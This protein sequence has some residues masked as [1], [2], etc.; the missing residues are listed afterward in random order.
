MEIMLISVILILAL[1]F[2]FTEK[3]TVDMVGIGIIV[4]LMLTRILSPIEAVRGF[5]NPAVITVGSMFIISRGMIRTGVVAFLARITIGL[6]RGNRNLMMLVV[7]LVVAGASAFINNTPVVVLFIPI[8]LSLSCEYDFS[9]SKLLIPMSY[10]SI[11]GGTCTLIGTSTNIIVSDLS[12]LYGFGKISM[13]ELSYL[14]VPLA[15]LGIAVIYLFA[16]YAMPEHAVPV[17]ELR[18]SEHRRYLAE[19]KVPRGSRMIGKNPAGFLAQKY[20]GIDVF[21]L[22]RYSHVFYPKEEDEVIAAADDLLLVKGELNDL[23]G[24][25]HDKIVELSQTAEAFNFAA[26]ADKSLI[27]ELIVPPQSSLVGERVSSTELHGDPDYHVIA[28]K[29]TYLRYYEKQIRNVELR[30]GDILLVR[31]PENRLDD[32]RRTGDFIIVEDVHHEIILKSKAR[33]AFLIFLGIVAAASSGLADIMEC[34]VTGVFLMILTGCIKLR[35][36][37]RAVQG[38]VL[39]LIVGAIALGA[40]MEKTGASEFYA[41][42]FLRAFR[43]AEPVIVLGG[44]LLLTSLST[45]LLSNNAAAALLLPIAISTAQALGVNPK[46]FIIA[47]CFGASACYSTPIGY[48]TN[49]LVFGPGNYRFRDYLKLGIPLNILVICMGILFIP[50][51]WPF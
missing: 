51:I 10:V 48:Q 27:V 28:I 13:F 29:R 46:P 24:I 35:D 38:D 30:V 37:Y 40:A 41:N 32:L 36:A 15:L 8:I 11:L 25:L 20:P 44:F 5:A 18:D 34:A 39:I 6:S 7:L 22:I 12:D 26:M 16:R 19:L 21:E 23:V 49:L 47:V 9:P 3:M 2:L 45:Q 33:W 50:M 42:G 4:A 1:V 31:C 17:C 14:G 43:G